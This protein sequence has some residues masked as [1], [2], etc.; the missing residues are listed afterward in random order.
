MPT[1]TR[2][3]IV[4][5]G[6][7]LTGLAAAALLARAGSR[8][9]VLE[10]DPEG[11]PGGAEAAWDCWHRPGVPQFRQ[12]HIMLPRWTAVMRRELPEVLDALRDLGGEPVNLLHLYPRSA[13]G[14]WQPG[15]EV[16]ETLTA[17][18]PVLETAVARVAA[19]TPGVRTRRGVAATGLLTTPRDGGIPRV[20]GVRTDHGDVAADLV[21]DAGGRHTPVP[22]FVRE[23]GGHEPLLIRALSGFVYYTRHY[24]SKNGLL[25]PG[26]GS[27]LTHHESYSLLTLPADN[28]TWSVGII[29]ST[30][31]RALRVLR[32]AAAWEAAVRATREG[33][34]WVEGEVLTP[35]RPFAGIE[36]I[37]RS[38]VVDGVPVVTGLVPLADASAAT[39]PSLGRGASI[40]LLQ[41]CVLRDV[42][43]AAGSDLG[44]GDVATAFEAA[45]ASTVTPFV[46]ATIAFGRHR[47]AEMEAEVAGRAYETTDP[48]WRMSCALMAGARSD[49]VLVRAYARIGSL[50][51]LPAEAL[52][53]PDVQARVRPFLAAARYPDGDLG[54]AELLAAA[55]TGSASPRVGLPQS[56]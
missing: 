50:L 21:V 16:F 15:D 52:A 44:S 47:L 31:D 11:A 42:V 8:V 27:A 10:R 45:T 46:E 22:R 18:R 37:R 20:V 56:A 13:T 49:P 55:A 14:G 53:A 7:G 6:G 24:R 40:G 36:D 4:L 29:A 1:T 26:T 43:A 25:P 38:Y 32:D 30:K 23:A 3:H 17:R 2:P 19:A 35:V 48:G 51:A 39:N 9:T 33:R 41:A 34:A 12:L 5:I 28:C 54:R